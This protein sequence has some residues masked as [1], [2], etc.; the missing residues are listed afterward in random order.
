[1]TMLVAQEPVATKDDLPTTD[2]EGTFRYVED[3]EAGYIYDG[4]A[5]LRFEKE[6]KSP[7]TE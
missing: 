5:W 2:P 6:E 1:M 7:A 3:E 4:Q